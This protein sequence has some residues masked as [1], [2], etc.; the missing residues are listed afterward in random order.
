MQPLVASLLRTLD[1]NPPRLLYM[2]IMQSLQLVIVFQYR[3]IKIMNIHTQILYVAEYIH[4]Y[5]TVP[6]SRHSR[7]RCTTKWTMLVKKLEGGNT[8]SILHKVTQMSPSSRSISSC[9]NF[10]EYR[11]LN[12]A[13]ISTRGLI[14]LLGTNSRN[15]IGRS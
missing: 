3:E 8:Y 1:L 2:N 4:L 11:P 15:A 10:V 9:V 5:Y 7:T 13:D 14:M 12:N 6:S